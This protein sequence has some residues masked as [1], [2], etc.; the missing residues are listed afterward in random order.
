[1]QSGLALSDEVIVEQ[2]LR[3]MGGERVEAL[4]AGKPV[5]LSPIEAVLLAEIYATYGSKSAAREALRA[6]QPASQPS[7]ELVAVPTGD[8]SANGERTARR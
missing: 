6:A 4:R 8:S 1:V 5:R 7:I 3:M 2:L